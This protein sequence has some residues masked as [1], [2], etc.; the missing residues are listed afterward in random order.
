[1]YASVEEV[2][3]QI[4]DDFGIEMDIYMVMQN[5]MQ[6]L[7]NMGMMVNKKCAVMG[8]AE[9]QQ[10]RMPVG[11]YDIKAVFSPNA[12]CHVPGNSV[13]LTIQDIWFPSAKIF[14]PV[15]NTDTNTQSAELTAVQ[16]NYI[17]YITGPQIDFEWEPP[18]LKFNETA[19]EVIA[20]YSSIKVEEKSGLPAIPRA[21]LEACVNYCI[22]KHYRPLFYTKKIDGQVY[23]EI[24]SEK[25]RFM[26]KAETKH[27]LSKLNQNEMSKVFDIMSSFNRKRT[28][29]DS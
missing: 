24:K 13:T 1:M 14:V 16:L 18:F 15:P 8:V 3:S 17:P 9:D 20:I 10:L 6:C 26:A 7:N 29:I 28:N 22:W 19:P 21:A 27:M 4:V 12:L 5:S 11:A 25:R 2:A 23:A